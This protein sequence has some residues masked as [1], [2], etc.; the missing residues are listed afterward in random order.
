[1]RIYF[2]RGSATTYYVDTIVYPYTRG[3]NGHIWPMKKA[4]LYIN[5]K[6]KPEVYLLK[7]YNLKLTSDVPHSRCF[8]SNLP[9]WNGSER[10]WL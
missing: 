1:V 2:L 8:G 6:R 3:P 9:V 4:L 5:K 10:S 7:N